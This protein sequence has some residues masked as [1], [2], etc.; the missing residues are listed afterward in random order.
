MALAGS[1]PATRPT[2]S[3][4]RRIDPTA[5]DPN[6]TTTQADRRELAAIDPTQLWRAPIPVCRAAASRI[7]TPTQEPAAP[8]EPDE[9]AE[10]SGT[11]RTDAQI[12]G[13]RA[14]REN[15]EITP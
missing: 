15:A 4:C 2:A 8:K 7:G 11:C 12:L 10:R 1:T 5:S 14:A 6:P 3:R 13:N 9:P